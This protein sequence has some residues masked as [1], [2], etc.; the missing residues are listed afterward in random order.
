MFQ[1]F[2]TF[3]EVPFRHHQQPWLPLIIFS[4]S[5]PRDPAPKKIDESSEK[6]CHSLAINFGSPV[7]PRLPLSIKAVFTRR[8]NAWTLVSLQVHRFYREPRL[9]SFPRVCRDRILT[10]TDFRVHC[11][12]GQQLN[13]WMMQN[14]STCS[15]YSHEKLTRDPP[16]TDYSPT[17]SGQPICRF[18]PT[19]W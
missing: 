18:N 1:C 8:M 11:I 5:C 12:L 13:L 19:H 14:A 15:R 4:A 3:S 7:I 10:S 16:Q 6:T 17:R 2:F 9:P